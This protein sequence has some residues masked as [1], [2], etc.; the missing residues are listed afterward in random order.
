MKGKGNV[1]ELINAGEILISH[2]ARVRMFERNI[3]TD[4]IITVISS[5]E[6]IEDYPDDDPCPSV[7][8]LGRINA[9]AYHIVIALCPDH[10]RVIT[11][12]IP[13]EKKWIEY[14][15]RKSES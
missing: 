12:Y 9:T 6:I 8:I 11:V 3:S 4:D 10:I 14:R 1:A 5:G 7:L 13:E 15:R 2:H